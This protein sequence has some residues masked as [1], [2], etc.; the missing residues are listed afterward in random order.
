MLILL[1]L[2][3]SIN[4]RKP[5]VVTFL[6]II[7]NTAVL[8]FTHAYDENIA[9]SSVSYYLDSELPNIELPRYI[10]TPAAIF[11]SLNKTA[12]IAAI[13]N[14]KVDKVT[15]SNILGAMENDAAFMKKLHNNEIVTVQDA[16]YSPWKIARSQF[17]ELRQRAISSRYGFIPAQH[18][19]VTFLT[20]Q[21]LHGGYDHLFGNMVFLFLIGYTLE[22]TLGSLLYLC[23]YLISGLGAVALYW[24][25]YPASETALIGASGAIAGLMGMYA[26][27]FGMRKIRFFYSLLFYFDFIKAP[28]LIMLPLWLANEIYQLYYTTGSQVAYM[29]HVGG[30]LT[31]G[32]IAMMIK[33]Y[34]AGK[35]DA[36]YLDESAQ[37]DEKI[38]RYEQGMK[39]L[40]ALKIGQSQQIFSGLHAQY[41]DDLDILMQYYKTLK[42]T[43]DLDE[44]HAVAARIFARA[45]NYDIRQISS[46]FDE[47]IKN[48]KKAQISSALLIKLVLFFCKNNSP[49]EAE[50]ITT[51]LLRKSAAIEGLDQAL[52]ALAMAWK[53]R[54]DVGKYSS[55]LTALVKYYPDRATGVNAGS[56]LKV[57][58]DQR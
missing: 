31:G 20:H 30:L 13:K 45:D 56:L 18:R 33:H 2:E 49:I 52:F 3:K 6:L 27:L 58:Y 11:N 25:V 26:G 10:Q 42:Y 29:A 22:T 34:F 14:Q 4:W 32:L 23:C 48:H 17:D 44:Y 41:P 57:P 43:P 53:R 19:P 36:S 54:G 47:Y 50:I 39:L 40:R 1:P 55:C 24:Q 51:S 46:V 9:Q 21:F 12:L 37:Q 38:L 15:L 28:A 5:P 35:I 7:I 8:F 16:D